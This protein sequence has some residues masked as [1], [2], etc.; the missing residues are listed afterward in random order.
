[1]WGSSRPSDTDGSASC[2][3]TSVVPTVMEAMDEEAEEAAVELDA[4]E[5]PSVGEETLLQRRLHHSVPS[6][7]LIVELSFISN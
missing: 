2:A 5:E 1:M 3:P 7:I 4:M 6:G